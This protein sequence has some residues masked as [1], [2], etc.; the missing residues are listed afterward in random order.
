MMWLKLLITTAANLQSVCLK[1]KNK[2]LANRKRLVFLCRVGGDVAMKIPTNFTSSVKIVGI[3]AAEEGK[4]RTEA[5]KNGREGA[6]VGKGVRRGE[7]V[8][9]GRR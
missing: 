3:L 2:S 8:R 7:G 9:S 5:R 6:K 4:R 1:E